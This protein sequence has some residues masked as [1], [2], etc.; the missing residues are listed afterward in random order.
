MQRFARL[1]ID[2]WAVAV[3]RSE[4][5]SAIELSAAVAASTAQFAPDTP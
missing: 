5:A 1:S 4:T 2:A 3:D